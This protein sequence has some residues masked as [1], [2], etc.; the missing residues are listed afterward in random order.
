MS[1]LER[2]RPFIIP[3]C[4][5]I[6]W[7]I[8]INSV[9]KLH[10]FC[11]ANTLFIIEWAVILR[12]WRKNRSGK[13]IHHIISTTLIYSWPPEWRNICED[14]NNIREVMQRAIATALVLGSFGLFVLIAV[15]IAMLY[16]KLC[17]S[18]KQSGNTYQI[19]FT[20]KINAQIKTNRSSL[21]PFY[22]VKINGE[23]LPVGFQ[24]GWRL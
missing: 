19:S 3:Y 10:H 23:R 18:R 22:S 24:R 11:N 7:L 20:G 21:T 8:H 9:K 1:F 14:T 15:S 17:S 13:E 5:K 4:I 16:H 2:D 12:S 6:A